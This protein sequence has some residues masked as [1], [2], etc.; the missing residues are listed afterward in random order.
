MDWL[1]GQVD[2]ENKLRLN[3]VVRAVGGGFEIGL[4]FSNLNSKRANISFPQYELLSIPSV[5]IMHSSENKSESVDYLIT[6][7]VPFSGFFGDK[8]L[9]IFGTV[10]LKP[11]ESSQH[12]RYFCIVKPDQ[13]RR[14]REIVQ[15]V[16][17]LELKLLVSIPLLEKTGAL[18]SYKSFWA[19]VILIHVSKANLEECVSVWTKARDSIRDLPKAMPEK[20]LL[21]ILEASKCMD[22]EVSK[23]AVVMSRR[24]LQGALLIKGADKTQPLYKQIDGLKDSGVISNDVAS[25]AH[26]IRYLGNFG[27]HPDDDLLSDV[28]FDDAKL[29]Y[30]VILK[31][32]KQLF[33][34]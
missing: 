1:N 12:M 23:A 21:D 10:E 4:N 13:W 25:L 9:V 2:I 18:W 28:S 6:S 7:E 24:A 26:G 15:K 34:S 33:P 22:I 8:E 32:L 20:V 3:A 27:A 5:T 11:E 14:M 16:G 17:L 29:A 31:I 30:Q 19:L